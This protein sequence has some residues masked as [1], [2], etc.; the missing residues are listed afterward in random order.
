MITV[1]VVDDDRMLLDG[2]RSWLRD[3]PGLRV[4]AVAATVD[5][6]LARWDRPTAVVLL[7]LVLRDDSTP[8]ANIHRLCATGSRVLVIST[9]PDRARILAAL[10]AGADG[11][12]TKDNDLPT[13]V[14]AIEG[15]ALRGAAHSPELAF[16]CA[17]DDRPDR[18]R[19]SPRELQVLL[20]YASGLTLKSAARRAG[21]TPNTAKD[22]LDRVKA[23][24]QRA[25]RPTYT[26]TDLAHRVRED[27]LEHE[28]GHGRG[29]GRGHGP[30][31]SRGTG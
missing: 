22:Y 21:I 19:L 5:E 8:A 17:H 11:Y 2:M 23:K 4:A 18:P 13:L 6:L 29:H 9:V 28:P 31:P 3:V 7:D 15:I 12:L 20:D 25:G 16:A 1:A 10:A 30:G 27:G 14:A 26:K 24:Y